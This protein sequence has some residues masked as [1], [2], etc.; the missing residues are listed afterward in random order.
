MRRLEFYRLD[1]AIKP[2]GLCVKNPFADGCCENSPEPAD[3]ITCRPDN[4]VL[5]FFTSWGARIA[6]ANDV[7]LAASRIAARLLA[8]EAEDERPSRVALRGPLEPGTGLTV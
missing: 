1:L 8:D 6:R 4:G 3:T 5:W 7:D 2:D